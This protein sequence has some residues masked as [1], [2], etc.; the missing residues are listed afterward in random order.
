[1]STEWRLVATRFDGS[2]RAVWGKR[3][4]AHALKGVEDFRRDMLRSPLWSGGDV[5]VESRT[6]SEWGRPG[7]G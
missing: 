6:V 2:G 1:M 4:E 5:W 7:G 3:D